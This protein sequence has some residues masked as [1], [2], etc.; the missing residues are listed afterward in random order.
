M[1]R[2]ACTG[3]MPSC[4]RSTPEPGHVV[5]GIGD[6]PGGRQEVLD[7]GRL[8]EPQPAV[9][10]ER[11]AAGGQ[12]HLQHVAVVRRP[13]QHGL[14]AQ[15]GA[16]FVRLQD[17]G[18]DLAGLRGLVV[19]AH[20]HRGGPGPA[21]AGEL[22]LQ[23]G[24]LRADRVGQPQHRL[25]RP[26]VRGQPD[27][28]ETGEIVRPAGAGAPGR[29]RGRRRWPGRRR[30]RRSGPASGCSS[31]TMSACTALTSWYSSTSTASNMPRS[32]G[33]AAGSASAARH[34]SSRSSK[35][36][37]PWLRLCATKSRNSSAS[38]PVNSVHQGKSPRDDVADRS[39]GCSRTGCRCRRR[40][41]PAARG[42]ACPPGR[43]PPGGRPAGRSCRTG[44]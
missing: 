20:Q 13:H 44:R 5:G 23:P 39:S 14:L 8:G 21:V 42:A 11:D 2:R 18:A 32:T 34:S 29:R 40:R 31:R 9:L 3:P 4:S 43:G 36:T 17:P 19:A 26:V 30:R 16:G 1:I 22:E 6:H 25:L 10:H 33:P 37:R 7:V 15:L 28:G 12:L 38:W 35:S 41:R 27:G 24:R